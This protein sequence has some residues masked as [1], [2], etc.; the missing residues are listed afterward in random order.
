MNPGDASY[1]LKVTILSSDAI[2]GAWK[3]GQNNVISVTHDDFSTNT[4][5]YGVS[6]RVYYNKR[7]QFDPSMSGAGNQNVTFSINPGCLL[8][9][10]VSTFVHNSSV[11]PTITANG[12]ATFCENDSVVLKS[13]SSMDNLWS[14]GGETADSIV[15]KTTGSYTVEIA[16][17]SPV[18]TPEVVTLSSFTTN[19]GLYSSS[20]GCVTKTAVDL[21]GLLGGSPDMGGTWNDDDMT[22]ELTGSIF[23]ANATGVGIYNFTYTTTNPAPCNDQSATVTLT[24]ES[25]VSIIELGEQLNF[26]A[27]PNPTESFLYVEFESKQTGINSYTLEITDLNGRIVI[28]KEI[29]SKKATVDVRHI[30]AGVYQLRIIHGQNIGNKKLIIK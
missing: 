4:R 13:S 30:K 23:N 10:T 19:P 29:E 1:P 26:V 28:S 18:S 8:D 14:P 7:S 12:P 2:N 17:C 21:F 6:A 9:T 3:V 27:Y 11:A 20:M 15:V 24:I 22:G 25:C 16:G 5:M